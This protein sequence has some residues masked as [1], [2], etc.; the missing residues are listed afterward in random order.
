MYNPEDSDLIFQRLSSQEYQLLSHSVALGVV[1]GE[2]N[3]QDDLTFHYS[4]A[5]LLLFLPS[6]ALRAAS[7]VSQKRYPAP[8]QSIAGRPRFSRCGPGTS[9]ISI[10][11]ELIEMENLGALPRYTESESACYQDPKVIR[12]HIIIGEVLL[13]IQPCLQSQDMLI[14]SRLRPEPLLPSVSRTILI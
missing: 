10:T 14:P 6:A 2:G 7:P 4:L 3:G 8:I 13:Q 9:S 1:M 5:H 12:R 11:K